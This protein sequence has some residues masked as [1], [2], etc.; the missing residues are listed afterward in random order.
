[1]L[2]ARG[3]FGKARID[4][5]LEQL[6]VTRHI[7]AAV[8]GFAAALALARGTDLVATV[9][10]RHTGNLRN[11]LHTFPLP[12]A[13]PPFTLSMLWHPRMDADPVHQWF[14]GCVQQVC[15]TNR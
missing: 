6:G 14:R 2:I 3:G 8:G 1:V 5:A 4:E 7:G 9:P 15:G 13:L 12:F 10:E 11:G